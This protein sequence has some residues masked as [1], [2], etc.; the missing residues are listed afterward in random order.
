M[1]FSPVVSC[2]TDGR[3]KDLSKTSEADKGN[4]HANWPD[5]LTLPGKAGNPIA[6]AC[7]KLQFW[8]YFRRHQWQT[9]EIRVTCQPRQ[10]KG[11]S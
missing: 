7:H 11:M 3:S 4:P 8:L 1:I 2:I 9:V 10:R 6:L 5:T